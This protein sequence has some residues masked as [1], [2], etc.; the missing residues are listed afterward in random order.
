M[1]HVEAA[2]QWIGTPWHH[3]GRNEHG[4]D[5]IGLLVKCFPVVDRFNYDR[6]P[7]GGT[8]EAEVEVQ[9]GNPVTDMQVGD[10]VLMAFPD[11]IRHVGILGERNGRFTLIHT[12]AGGP[13]KVVEMPL[14]NK[15]R[16]RIKRVHR[17][18]K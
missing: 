3:Q 4:L 13:R 7:R 2:R 12:W 10:V 14:D 5:C 6:N 17:W 9:F 1:N 16:N 18:S 8:L 11:V 15:W